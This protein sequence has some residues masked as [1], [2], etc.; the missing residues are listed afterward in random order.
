MYDYKFINQ[1]ILDIS[2]KPSPLL[3]KANLSKAIVF[4][5]I[6]VNYFSAQINSKAISTR[7]T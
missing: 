3:I 2:I 4:I 6:S 5:K 7:C 1:A